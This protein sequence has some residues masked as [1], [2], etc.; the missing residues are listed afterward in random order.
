MARMPEAIWTPK[1]IGSRSRRS[2]GRGVVYHVAVSEAQNLMPGPDADWHFYVAKDGRIYQYIDT[3]FQAWASRD[4][5]ASMIA[6][7]TQGGVNDPQGERWTAAQVASL[8]GIARFAHTSEGVPLQLMQSSL[9]SERG[10]GWHRL[11]I[12]PW[13]VS[14]GEL[15]S[16]A[17]GKVCPGDAKIA[18]MPEVLRLALNGA[19]DDMPYTKE[20]IV[21]MVREGVASASMGTSKAGIGPAD[22][23]TFI[24]RLTDESVAMRAA[25][26][27]L[28]EVIAA[29]R[30]D[31][32]AT[33]LRDAVAGALVDAGEALRAPTDPA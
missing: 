29:G 15:W 17:R 23:D 24:L 4:G 14:G 16:G 10:L 28:A 33:E 21:A 30:D 18:Q 27:K 26:S 12:D 22:L 3:D 7:E 13:R 20:Q 1:A 2:K 5:N 6:V 25:V 31:L 9:P 32:T 8:A 11:G 19:E